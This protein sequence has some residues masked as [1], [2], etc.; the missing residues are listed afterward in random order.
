MLSSLTACSN[1]AE[2]V[3]HYEIRA[4]LCGG[5][6]SLADVTPCLGKKGEC[7]RTKDQRSDW[8]FPRN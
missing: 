8:K 1:R 2:H 5:Q 3:L 7:P 6:L 4:V